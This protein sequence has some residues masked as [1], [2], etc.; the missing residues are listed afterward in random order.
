MLISC[1]CFLIYLLGALI[2][3]RVNCTVQ[4]KNYAHGS[5]SF[6]WGCVAICSAQFRQIIQDYFMGNGTKIP[7]QKYVYKCVETLRSL[8]LC[9]T[10]IAMWPDH[11][12][13]SGSQLPILRWLHANYPASICR[14]YGPRG[15]ASPHLNDFRVVSTWHVEKQL[16]VWPQN[17]E[18]IELPL[19]TILCGMPCDRCRG[20]CRTDCV[21]C[22]LAFNSHLGTR[23]ELVLRW[24]PQNTTNEMSTSV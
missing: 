19:Q 2:F 5:Q 3:R 15:M 14:G 18:C 6:L 9:N 13:V 4:P 11:Y 22:S 7:R 10:I 16:S 23:C 12:G 21:S 8:G 17:I 1:I 20:A 24:M